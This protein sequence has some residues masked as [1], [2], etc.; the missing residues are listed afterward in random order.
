AELVASSSAQWRSDV[1]REATIQIRP[2]PRRDMEADVAR[3]ARLAQQVPGIAAVEPFSKAQSERLLEPW[4][5][6]GLDFNDLPVPRLIVL[7][8]EE[9]AHPDFAPLRETLGREVPGAT[10]D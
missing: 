4:L 1:A 7:K 3:A 9:N 6:T 5:G 2:N 10:L 8:L